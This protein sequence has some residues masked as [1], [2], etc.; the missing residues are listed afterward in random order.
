[1]IS[2][3]TVPKIIA[4]LCYFLTWEFGRELSDILLLLPHVLDHFE[5]YG[6]CAALV[7]LNKS[8]LHYFRHW[9]ATLKL[10]QD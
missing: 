8:I 1:M 5:K 10:V 7:I 3:S 4:L 9:Y 6:C 2:F